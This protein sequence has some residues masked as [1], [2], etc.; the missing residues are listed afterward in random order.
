MLGKSSLVLYKSVNQ[1]S[2]CYSVQQIASLTII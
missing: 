1:Q 2:F